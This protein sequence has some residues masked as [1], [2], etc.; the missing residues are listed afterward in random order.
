MSN[1][2]AGGV[3]KSMKTWPHSGR[4]QQSLSLN[5][6]RRRPAVHSASRRP[7]RFCQ[8]PR[9]D[10]ARLRRLPRQQAVYHPGK[11]LGK[12]E[13]LYLYNGLR[14]SPPG[15]NLGRG[16]R[17]RRRPGPP[18]ITDAEGLQSAARTG[19]R[20]SKLRRGTPIARSTSRKNST[21][22]T[23]RPRWPHAMPGS[24]NWKRKSPH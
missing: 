22:P 4:D 14:P 18:G 9:Q 13:G 20:V 17:G 1:K 7:K 15:E 12:S 21:Q 11:S 3:P 2:A 8:N 19:D 23:W 24:P 6:Q 5:R 10:H 16:A